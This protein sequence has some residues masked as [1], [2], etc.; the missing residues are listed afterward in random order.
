M[1]RPRKPISHFTAGYPCV[2][3]TCP[4]CGAKPGKPCTRGSNG[5]PYSSRRWPIAPHRKRHRA[6]VATP[7]QDTPQARQELPYSHDLA[8][9]DF[10]AQ[11]PEGATLEQIGAF[12]GVTREWVRQLEARA[13]EKLRAGATLEGFDNL[14][15]DGDRVLHADVEYV[16]W[17]PS[18][19]VFLTGGRGNGRQ[20][21]G[22]DVPK[23][24]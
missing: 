18:D 12:F 21:W 8:A 15:R 9:Q 19:W 6:L 3:V 23:R 7:A 4:T 24:S 13:L 2:A 22:N 5:T 20:G 10:V 1:A 14:N 17:A 11:H 16:Q